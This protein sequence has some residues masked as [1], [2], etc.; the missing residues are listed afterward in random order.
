MFLKVLNKV[1]FRISESLQKPRLF[2][3]I[4]LLPF[5]KLLELLAINHSSSKRRIIFVPRLLEF[6]HVMVAL[7]LAW[8]CTSMQLSWISQSGLALFPGCQGSCGIVPDG[9]ADS[10]ISFN[11][12][13]V[14]KC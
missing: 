1:N 14:F 4:D 6:S 3:I 8:V 9:H 13:Q 7:E 12:H 2:L 10:V 11:I 5:A